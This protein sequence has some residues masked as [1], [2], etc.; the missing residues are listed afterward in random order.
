[1]PELLSFNPRLRTRLPPQSKVAVAA[2]HTNESWIRAWQ[3]QAWD[4]SLHSIDVLLREL[5]RRRDV[6]RVERKDHLPL[7]FL[8]PNAWSREQVRRAA[9]AR[10]G[11]ATRVAEMQAKRERWLGRKN[12]PATTAAAT[13]AAEAEAAAVTAAEEKKLK[14]AP[15]PAELSA[16][17]RN[18]AAIA[19]QL[20]SGV[21][22]Q[23]ESLL[24]SAPPPLPVPTSTRYGR[25]SRSPSRSGPAGVLGGGQNRRPSTLLASPPLSPSP[26][27][28]LVPTL[29]YSTQVLA[30]AEASEALSQRTA[31]LSA[32]NTAHD[33]PSWMKKR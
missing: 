14:Q 22:Q 29:L 17:D 21:A 31:K 20:H 9:R 18:A 11:R 23:K 30:L 19:A 16:L 12:D 7:A 4:E 32:R 13:A 8:W 28:P 2:R 26:P 15:P 25:S 1:M 24:A 5:S 27:S 33:L 6:A 10:E 3:E